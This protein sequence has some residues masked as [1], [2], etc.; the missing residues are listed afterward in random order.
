MLVE[1]L[2]IMVILYRR[3][4]LLWQTHVPANIFI[5]TARKFLIE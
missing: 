2:L 4:K 5:S 3:H 1:E